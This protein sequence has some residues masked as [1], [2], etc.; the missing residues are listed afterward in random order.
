MVVGEAADFSYE[1]SGLAVSGF[2]LRAAMES[3]DMAE[4]K[5]HLRYLHDL[6]RFVFCALQEEGTSRERGRG[7]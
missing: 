5:G 2:D 1:D 6:V 4:V 3:R 7:L